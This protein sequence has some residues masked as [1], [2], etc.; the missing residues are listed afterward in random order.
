MFFVLPLL[1]TKFQ[2][3]CNR[4][5]MSSCSLIPLLCHWSVQGDSRLFFSFSL[6][7]SL[8]S[9]HLLLFFLFFLPSFLY[10]FPF[11]TS[12][13]S[14]LPSLIL[15]FPLFLCFKLIFPPCYMPLLWYYSELCLGL[16]CHD[17]FTHRSPSFF[18][19]KTCFKIFQH[20]T[21]K[22]ISHI[23]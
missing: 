16:C 23:F 15:L 2:E 17:D 13:Y 8:P 21:F 10:S 4:Y 14:P 1:K 7:H 18:F 22:I 11:P 5:F 6:L 19:K 9:S 20:S 12:C 3:K